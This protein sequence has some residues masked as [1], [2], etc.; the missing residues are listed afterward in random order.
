MCLCGAM[1]MGPC[2]DWK[3]VLDPLELELQTVVSNLTRV[4]G[5]KL[6]LCKS[7]THS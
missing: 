5:A 1:S 6:C 3:N 7:T 4:L 2:G